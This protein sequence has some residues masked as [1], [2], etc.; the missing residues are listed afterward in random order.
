MK[1]STNT[2]P[3]VLFFLLLFYPDVEGKMSL[4]TT[5]LSSKNERVTFAFCDKSLTTGLFFSPYLVSLLP[6]ARRWTW[7]SHSL[8]KWARS[9]TTG[10]NRWWEH[11]LS[12]LLRRRVIQCCWLDRL[13]APPPPPVASH[14]VHAGISLC[15]SSF[16]SF[17]NEGCC[18]RSCRTSWQE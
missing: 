4:S 9:S 15:A 6:D 13:P 7:T 8:S 14:P 17:T 18:W 3:V 10:P 16:S 1:N 5:R 11:A 12:R 2:V